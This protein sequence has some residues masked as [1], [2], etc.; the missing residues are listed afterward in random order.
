M[1]NFIALTVLVFIIQNTM[2]QGFTDMIDKSL[3]KATCMLFTKAHKEGCCSL[4]NS[5]CAKGSASFNAL[6]PQHV[7]NYES[8]WSYE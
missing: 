2:T 5:C 4:Y 8:K 7:K 1:K 3:C 6:F